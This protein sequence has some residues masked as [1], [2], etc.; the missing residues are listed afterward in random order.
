MKDFLSWVVNFFTYKE[1]LA[2]P[3]PGF[4]GLNFR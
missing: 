3:V 1:S 2:F 4:L